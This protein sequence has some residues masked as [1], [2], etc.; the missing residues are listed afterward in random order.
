MVFLIFSKCTLGYHGTQPDYLGHT[1]GGG[2]QVPP[3]YIHILTLL[4]TPVEYAAIVCLARRWTGLAAV[5]RTPAIEVLRRVRD[6]PDPFRPGWRVAVEPGNLEGMSLRRTLKQFQTFT[7]ECFRLGCPFPRSS[8]ALHI[9]TVQHHTAH[10]F[11]P[12]AD[13][14]SPP[15]PP[16]TPSILL[17]AEPI[18]HM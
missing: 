1:R 6:G 13:P 11:S 14:H 18:P 3:V 2:N 5:A 15:S 4:S 12:G 16:C 17:N 10:F 9:S 8:F 7:V